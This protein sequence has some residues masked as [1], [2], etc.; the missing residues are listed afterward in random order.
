LYEVYEAIEKAGVARR[1]E[2]PIWVDKEQK[3]TE[4]ENAFRQRATHLLTRPDFVIF[5]KLAAMSA[6]KEMEQ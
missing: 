3:E 2:E 6:K 1:L 4:Q 5:L